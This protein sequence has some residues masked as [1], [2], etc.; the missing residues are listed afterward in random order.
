MSPFVA[1]CSSDCC[2]QSAALKNVEAAKEDL[3]KLQSAC[4]E[5]KV[6]QINVEKK[7]PELINTDSFHLK[8]T[9]G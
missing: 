6:S 8:S 1:L 3:A 2:S 9:M 4:E 5:Q 7:N